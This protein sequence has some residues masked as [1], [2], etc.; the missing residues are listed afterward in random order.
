MQIPPK[1]KKAHEPHKVRAPPLAQFNPIKKIRRFNALAA[2]CRNKYSIP[3]QSDDV[4]P[5]Q[6][7]KAF[8]P[9][10]KHKFSQKQG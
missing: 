8:P 6:N 4:K 2:S 9:A 1:I 3:P 7:R 5:N 10:K